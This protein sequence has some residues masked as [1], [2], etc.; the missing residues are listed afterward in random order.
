MKFIVCSKSTGA[1]LRSGTCQD[2]MLSHQSMGEDEESLQH[3]DVIA[4]PDDYVV[5]LQT[6][7][8]SRKN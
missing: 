4:D 3:A 2:H 1:V 6:K 8:V 5:D 7:T